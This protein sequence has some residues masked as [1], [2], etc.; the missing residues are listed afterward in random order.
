MPPPF[1]PL[2]PDLQ[3]AIVSYLRAG[4]FP[5]VCAEAAGVPVAV[6]ADWMHQGE[7]PDAQPPYDDLARAARQAAAQGRLAAEIAVRDGRPLDW[8]RYGPGRDNARLPGWG[9]AVKPRAGAA[10]DA[11]LMSPSNRALLRALQICLAA[12]PEARAA[13]A[14]QF[15][16]E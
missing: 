15:G 9:A 5:E 16:E 3:H 12:F 13:V 14:S 2:T 10:E 1:F 4:G 11:G 6:F 7:G 8:L